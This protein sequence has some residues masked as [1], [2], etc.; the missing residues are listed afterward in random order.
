MKH[1]LT[2][3]TSTMDKRIITLR[4]WLLGRGYHVALAALE[5]AASFHTGLRKD[6][7]TPEFDHQ[8]RIALY[9]RTL[10][11]ILSFPEETL[12]SVFL[13]DV[14]ED[15]DVS[16]DE[17]EA[18]FGRT[19]RDAVVRLTK[20]HRGIKVP[21]DIYYGKMAKSPIASIVKGADRMHNMQTMA[22]VFSEAKQVS[23]IQETLDYV[24]P[25]LKEARRTFTKQE[26]V[27][28]NVKLVLFTQIELIRLALDSPPLSSE[29][30]NEQQI[31][32]NP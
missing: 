1:Q 20:I 15:H 12:A 16:F 31:Q 29:Q 3:K 6:G 27:Y 30:R 21:M 19:I 18:K 23:Y 4:Y 7:H 9:I 10:V 11:D 32:N 2:R 24:F 13:H 26:P 22:N 14:C 28:E 5:F 17:I 25:M 8:I